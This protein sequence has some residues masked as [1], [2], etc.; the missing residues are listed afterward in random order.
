MHLQEISGR[1][2]IE[3]APNVFRR[4]RNEIEQ[5]ITEKVCGMLWEDAVTERKRLFRLRIAV[6]E[7][8]VDAGRR[9]R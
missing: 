6:L 3:V 5:E 1:F 9:S 2:V 4:P 7:M 8:F